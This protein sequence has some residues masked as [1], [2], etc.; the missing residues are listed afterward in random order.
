MVLAGKTLPS[1]PSQ[2]LLSGSLKLSIELHSL[3]FW[4]PCQQG[5]SILAATPVGDVWLAEE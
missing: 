1:K 5:G 4:A 2:R 3:P